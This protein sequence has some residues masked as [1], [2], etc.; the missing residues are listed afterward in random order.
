[1]N[2]FNNFYYIESF[3]KGNNFNTDYFKGYAEIYKNPT[4]SELKAISKESYDKGIRFGIDDNND[5]YAWIED[6]L[7]EDIER[8]LKTDWKLRLEYTLNRD[9]LYLS[10]GETGKY[11]NDYGKPK[12]KYFKEI[13][14]SIN[15]IEM[16]TKP[17]TIVYNYEEVK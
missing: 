16:V 4:H 17:Y 13:M 2:K 1:M 3:Y 12:V 8:F 7:H 10:S 5:V 15:K 9:T 14:P 6:I 11:W